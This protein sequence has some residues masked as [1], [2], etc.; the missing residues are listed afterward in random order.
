MRSLYPPIRVH[1]WGGL[2]SQLFGLAL[3]FDLKRKYFYRNFVLV[4]HNGGVTKRDPD[5]V[6]LL[7]DLKF[8]VLDDY[9]EISSKPSLTGQVLF[10]RRAIT[11][12]FRIPGRIFGFIAKGNTSKE[13]NRIRP[14]VLSIR[15]HYSTRKISRDAVLSIAKSFENLLADNPLAANCLNTIGIHYRLGDLIKLENKKPINVQ[16]L[17]SGLRRAFSKIPGKASVVICSDSPDFAFTEINQILREDVDLSIRRLDPVN[18]IK[19][20]AMLDQFVGSPSK[21]S[22][23]VTMIRSVKNQGEKTFLPLEMKNQIETTLGSAVKIQYF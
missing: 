16:R 12:F 21:I 4:F 19:F 13:F 14:W 3:L 7:N 18:T 20:L 6:S 15:G 11:S 23:W 5:L 9:Q 2:G 17:I 22:E 10:F 1:V 8:E